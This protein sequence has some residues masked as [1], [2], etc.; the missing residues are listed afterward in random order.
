MKMVVMVMMVVVMIMP[1]IV[2]TRIVLFVM[3]SDNADGSGD[4]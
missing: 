1:M 4:W 2:A 3:V